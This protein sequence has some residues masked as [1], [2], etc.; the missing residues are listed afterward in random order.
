MPSPYTL[1]C[2]AIYIFYKILA[3]SNYGIGKEIY[4]FFKTFKQKYS[5]DIDYTKATLQKMIKIV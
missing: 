3:D 2:N 4:N 5:K 1:E